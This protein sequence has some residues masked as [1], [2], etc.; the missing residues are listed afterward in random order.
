MSS[1][2]TQV[3]GESYKK[4]RYLTLER[5]ISYYFQFKEVTSLPVE[6]LLEIGIGN[7]I[8]S[9]G[10]R[11][12]GYKVTTCDFDASVQPD[13]VADV[14]HLPLPDQSQD[15]V[16]ACQILEHLPFEEFEAALR[17]LM[18]V[19]RK[20]VLISLPRR[21]T[22]FELIVKFPG[23]QTLLKRSYIDLAALIP[24]RFPGFAESGQH[25]WEIDAWQV[26]LKR[27]K[28]VMERVGVVKKVFS[29]PMNKYHVFFLVE[30]KMGN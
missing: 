5:F 27:V 18:R 22:G 25:Y 6:S 12:M 21:H 1:F 10:L 28:E 19:S 24:L 7:G 20:Y 17:E 15:L 3:S 26:S 23:I 8:V 14:R 11:Q 4:S 30:R 29:P 13:V 16:M 2:S 9:A